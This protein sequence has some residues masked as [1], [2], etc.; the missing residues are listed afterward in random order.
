[1]A[2]EF[3]HGYIDDNPYIVYTDNPNTTYDEYMVMGGSQNLTPGGGGGDVTLG[4]T[5]QILYSTSAPVVGGYCGDSQVFANV[6][7]GDSI[8]LQ[9]YDDSGV[10]AKVAGGA[11]IVTVRL[12]KVEGDNSAKAYII[13][14]DPQDYKVISF[15]EWDGEI[16][17]ID[18]EGNDKR[19]QFTVPNLQTGQLFQLEYS[20]DW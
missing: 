20:A 5:V 11:T 16:T 19:Y 3:K 2:E 15:T 14:Y 17:M 4:D 12:P 1:M 7:L 10:S 18:V 13:E 6:K 8:V 9:D